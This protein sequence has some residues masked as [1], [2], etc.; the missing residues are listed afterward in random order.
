[1]RKILFITLITSFISLESQ[2]E[3]NVCDA[4]FTDIIEMHE[5]NSLGRCKAGN[6]LQVYSRDPAIAMDI[7]LLICHDK[8][9]QVFTYE[10][11]LIHKD[12][13]ILHASCRLL[14]VE[15]WRNRILY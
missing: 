11:G 6:L 10:S 7:M 1:M 8:T 13:T 14:P 12:K 5:A 9:I 3:D 2:A 4:T 15:K